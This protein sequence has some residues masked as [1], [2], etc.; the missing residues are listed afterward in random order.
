M[1]NAFSKEKDESFPM[2]PKLIEKYQK[3]D[4]TL[5]KKIHN[6]ASTAYSVQTVEGVDLIKYNGRIC[7]PPALQQ[8]IVAWYHE[9]LAHPGQTRLEATLREIYTWSNLRTHVHEFCRTCDKC[10]L[11]KKQRKKYGHLPAKQAETTPWKRVNVDL[12]GPYKIKT[13]NDP[14][15]KEPRDLRA[16]TMI[17]PVTGWFEIKAI[18]KPDA[19]TVMDAFHDA[20]LCRY[21]RPE[22]IGFDN[23]SE[24]KDVFATTCKNYG[25]KEKHSTSHNPQSNGV[26]E[27]IHQVVGNS[28]RTFQ[29]ESA[30]LNED[31]PWTTYLV[32][33]AWAVRST[34]LTPRQVN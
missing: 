10:Q 11:S 18:L 24:F 20:W 21:P 22:Q 1:A 31:D 23:G 9:Y 6:D 34:Y 30:T 8:R 33:V 2:S 16:L 26:I 4:K 13:I 25:I 12:I 28:L 29:L 32:S 5:A 7:V 19:A 15:D 17:D 27:R 3:S 14:K